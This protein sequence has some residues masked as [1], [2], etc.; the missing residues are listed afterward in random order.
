MFGSGGGTGFGGFGQQ[1]QQNPQNQQGAQ[2][3]QT[4]GL[5][6]TPQQPAAGTGFGG[7]GAQP[8]TTF[9]GGN[10]SGS[11]FG[12]AA[13]QQQ[14][15]R[16]GGFTFG[17]T[18]NNA[19]STPFGQQN[20]AKPAGFGGFGASTSATPA[21]GTGFGG[22]GASQNNQ[23]QPSA[24]PFGGGGGATF[25]AKPAGSLFGQPQ[26]Q[27]S[28]G[29]PAQSGGLFGG[30]GAS[31]V[32][33]MPT[34]GT[35]NP[36][37]DL[38]P[39]PEGSP[40][41]PYDEIKKMPQ[42]L[43]YTSISCMKPYRGASLEELRLQDYEQGRKSGNGGAGVGAGVGGFGQSTSTGGFGAP[44]QNGGMFG[45]QQQQQPAAGGFGGGGG[46]FGQ[47][48]QQQQPAQAGGGLFGSSTSNTGGG[49]FGQPQQSQP[50]GLFGS[51]QQQQQ[52][53]ATGGFGA[54]QQQNASSGFTFGQNNNQQQQQQAK[55]AGGLF[56]G[57]G[58]GATNPAPGTS[59]GFSFGGANN[60][61]NQTATSGGFG[62]ASSGGFGFGATSATANQPKPGG[63][64]GA[65][66]TS[67]AP[68]FG[69]FG[70]T[71]A[72]P[73]N[74]SSSFSFGGGGFGGAAPGQTATAA[75]LGGGGLFGSTQPAT[76][77]QP[78][79]GFTFGGTNNNTASTGGLFGGQQQQQQQQQ[80]PGATGFGGASGGLFGSKPATGGLF[81]AAS[82]PQQQGATGGFGFGAPSNTV[83][84][85]GGGLFGNNNQNKPAGGG[86]F[87]SLGNNTNQQQPTA[88]GGLF[89][90]SQSNSTLGGGAAT[91]G[92]FGNSHTNQAGGGGLFGS[93]NQQASNTG[94][95]TGGGGLFGSSTLG[96][97][98][99]SFGGFGGQS[100]TQ[101]TLG[102]SLFGNSQQNQQGP[103]VQFGLSSNPYGTDALFGG[104]ASLN[105]GGSLNT[106]GSNQG[107]LNIGNGLNAQP[108][109]PFNVSLSRSTSKKQPPLVP[110][111]RPSS[112]NSIRITKLRGSTPNGSFRESTPG[113]EGTPGPSLFSSSPAPSSYQRLSS[114]S[115]SIFRGLSDDMPRNLSNPSTPAS[116]P[117]QAFVSRPSVK[118]LVLDDNRNSTTK[119][120]SRA[121]SLFTVR[122]A[123]PG[124]DSSPAPA[125]SIFERNGTPARSHVNFN[126]ALETAASSSGVGNESSFTTST[127]AA[128]ASRRAVEETPSKG[129]PADG[130]AETS[131]PAL[132]RS[133]AK[134]AKE[135]VLLPLDYWTSPALS[136][137]RD[138]SHAEL[139]AVEGFKVGRHGFGQVEFL[140]PVDLTTVGELGIIPGGLVILRTKEC[141]VYP[142]EGECL[143]F[144][145]GKER[146]GVQL[147]FEPRKIPGGKAE[148]GSGLNVPAEIQL[149][150][151]WPFDRSTRLPIKDEEHIRY[152]QHVNKL[153]RRADAQFRSFEP[154]KGTWTFRVEHFSRYGLDETDDDA[155]DDEMAD[156][157]VGEGEKQPG[158]RASKKAMP[159][160][161]KE[162]DDSASEGDEDM[163]PPARAL[164]QS[165]DDEQSEAE[166]DLRASE[167][168]DITPKKT[169]P[170]TGRRRLDR[171]GTPKASTPMYSRGSTPSR[172]SVAPSGMSAQPWAAS[173][174]LEARRVQV[175]QASFFGDAKEK[176]DRS[177][178]TSTR[179]KVESKQG[180]LASP[181]FDQADLGATGYRSN[182]S[183][184][185]V[186]TNAIVN[187]PDVRMSR[188]ASDN[189]G[190]ALTSSSNARPRKYSRLE[191]SSSVDNGEHGI[192]IDAGLMMGRSFRVGWGP[193][194]SFVHSGKWATPTAAA[195]AA[196]IATSSEPMVD[197][198]STVKMGKLKVI[199][200]EG[201][202][203]KERKRL[204]NLLQV[205]LEHSI[206]EDDED[207]SECPAI[208]P[209]PSLRFKDFVGAI[210]NVSDSHYETAIFKLGVAL[211]D[212]VDLKLN[213]SLE[214]PR[215]YVEQ[216]NSI[217]RKNNVANWLRWY[218]G[219]TVRNE[220]RSQLASTGKHAGEQNI[221]TFLSG[222]YFEEACKQALDIG[223]V[224]LATLIAQASGGGDE[225][226][227]RIDL[228][229]QL[230]VWGSS[231]VDGLISSE[232][233]RVFE[234]LSGNVT[235]SKG[236]GKRE[237][238]EAVKDLSIIEGLD[239]VRSFALFLHFDSRFDMDIS[240]SLERYESSVGGEA[241]VVPPLPPYLEKEIRPGSQQFRKAVRS[242]IYHRDMLF[243]LLKL[244][245]KP[246][247]ELENA[248]QPLCVGDDRLNFSIPFHLSLLL[249]KVLS[250]RDYSD[251]VDLG[252]DNYDV[253]QEA[254]LK[255]NSGRNDRLCIDFAM[256]LET[257]GLWRWAAFALL[258][259]ELKQS[260][261]E[262]I[263]ALLARNVDSIQSTEE[264]D[265]IKIKEED[266]LV[267]KLK[268]PV[269]WLYEAKAD[270]ASSRQDRWREFKYLLSADLYVRA[271]EIAIRF[272]APEGIIRQDFEFLL[273]LFAPFR[274]RALPLHAPAK[275]THST[276]DHDSEGGGEE[277]DGA[278]AAAAKQ[279]RVEAS[280]GVPGWARGG[281]IYLDYI[282]ICRSLPWLLNN[283]SKSHSFTSTKGTYPSKT[284]GS[285]AERDDEGGELKKIERMANKIPNLMQDIRELL[286]DVVGG[287]QRS[288]DVAIV[289]TMTVARSQM[290]TSLYTCIR[291]LKQ[292]P[293]VQRMNLDL[294]LDDEDSM[295]AVEE[296]RSSSGATSTG[297]RVP[298]EIENLQFFANDYCAML[299]GTA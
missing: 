208:F 287:V 73:E 274:Q 165:T 268:I 264:A 181:S 261:T 125:A 11:L 93:N 107:N 6:G 190:L 2:P 8:S 69:G 114:P 124:R 240:D 87:G 210:E 216:V 253:A 252:I 63:L 285:L 150:M 176:D 255:G 122:G 56:G 118:R 177:S 278:A 211:F 57:G 295:V 99:A 127:F 144:E 277:E 16:P 30:M 110:P 12:Q 105:A 92:M 229:D 83:G 180:R 236:N 270:R 239:W 34:Q 3:G 141:I 21:T 112:R 201:E 205:Q 61:T 249:S 91:G 121:N 60:Q 49:L 10:T 162:R 86:L 24:S 155:T 281:Q 206:I 258:H 51:A 284:S 65:P 189:F 116:L 233:R 76:A 292:S 202:G 288:S 203:N 123:T 224:R 290:V 191:V 89:G 79:G 275:A 78:T 299:I 272:L 215:E 9:G 235:M 115:S 46:L 244:F 47:N 222:G 20:Q 15:Q 81:G 70:A 283:Y 58:F 119:S 71:S 289:T 238:S 194:G 149:E 101:Q 111:F 245:C 286:I 135:D 241:D 13:Q 38:K 243:H 259:L 257:M 64:F 145:N 18:N 168:G 104:Q 25:G 28:F 294:Q 126:P 161:R 188:A 100:N 172:G 45:Q 167:L 293:L 80:Q 97:S 88:G 164:N 137:L 42:L 72:A 296:E 266:F 246:S 193:D 262:N 66:A 169:Q 33:P 204:E 223:D 143:N 260:R 94:A 96:G 139:Q 186:S 248:L 117:A 234:L 269:E 214:Q 140:S 178:R 52:Q 40:D 231:G 128:A 106:S 62:A 44:A 218:V 32:A 251:R 136:V 297:K 75:P 43:L 170:T 209:M 166:S 200:K 276:S 5:F 232:Y 271:H 225:E 74:K 17:Q 84:N 230:S 27:T 256:Q 280:H 131:L 242:G 151:C 158:K 147:G 192:V 195:A 95:G 148:R 179:E 31:Q 54:P 146:D 129:V 59:G 134:H 185:A 282:A 159:K 250:Q 102:G 187:T 113:R 35:T 217:R 156:Q 227:F 142:D 207:G 48:T 7:F 132:N 199:G 291:M 171:E 103:N 120:L 98:T 4:G 90:N 68:T 138:W 197:S 37:Y 109:L 174:G 237:E 36:P 85:T 29:Q 198:F 173:L 133:K 279:G 175:M 157:E 183:Q 55:P 153:K 298:V 82:Q 182:F 108:H 26:Q 23:A 219:D 196:A 130:A 220:V 154:S 221:F 22:F 163:P 254:N 212:E 152:K 14:P 184:P 67:S 53:P 39:Q 77:S 160:G 265:E 19:A 273:H 50:G 228:L 1:N 213:M 226:E 267:T 41:T 247:Y 263:Q